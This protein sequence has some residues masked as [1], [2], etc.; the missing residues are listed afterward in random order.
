MH[1]LKDCMCLARVK[2][3]TRLLYIGEPWLCQLHKASSSML[4]HS[5]PAGN[6]AGELSWARDQVFLR[7]RDAREETNLLRLTAHVGLPRQGLEQPGCASIEAGEPFWEA[8]WVLSR[9]NSH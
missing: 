3:C 8:G 2:A 5:A 6:G 7:V 9:R 1:A 4:K